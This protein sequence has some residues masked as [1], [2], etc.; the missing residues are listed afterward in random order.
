MTS[1]S[2]RVVRDEFREVKGGWTLPSFTGQ[3][4]GCGLYSSDENDTAAT[5]G[6]REAETD[7]I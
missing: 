2:G 5:A 3:G 7:M 1:G 4:K 6:I